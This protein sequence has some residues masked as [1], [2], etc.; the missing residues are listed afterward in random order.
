[1]PAFLIEEQFAPWLGGEAG[2]EYLKP[3]PN[4]YQALPPRARPHWGIFSGVMFVMLA[5]VFASIL[6]KSEPAR[7][8]AP[9]R[10][11]STLREDGKE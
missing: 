2:T 10:S 8:T 7:S 11:G 6:S 4:D 3:M 5:V 1:M 9:A